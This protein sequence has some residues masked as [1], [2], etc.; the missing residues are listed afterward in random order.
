MILPILFATLIFTP[1]DY[2]FVSGNEGYNCFR[3]PAII[4]APNGDVLAYAEGRTHRCSD[5]GDIDLVFKRSK[6]M[7]RLGSP[8]KFFGTK[9]DI[10][11]A[12]LPQ[13]LI[14]KLDP[15]FL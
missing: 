8:S 7:G 6:D 11:L 2:I 15:S 5:A 10:S 4:V 3:I 9:R 12:I 1:P 13:L 14:V